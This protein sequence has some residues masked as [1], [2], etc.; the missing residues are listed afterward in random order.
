MS[1]KYNQLTPGIPDHAFIRGNVPMTKEEVRSITIAKLQLCKDDVFMDIGA[2]TGSVSVE[3][4]RLL[5]QSK[6]YAIEH[7]AEAVELIKQNVAK[8]E[9][10]NIEVIHA[11]ALEAFENVNGVNK[12]FIGGSSGQLEGIINWVTRNCG[13]GTRIVANA[14]TLDTLFECKKLFS[15]SSFSHPE[16]IQ[17]GITKVET[18][19]GLQMMRA[20]SPIFII[21]TEIV[22]NNDN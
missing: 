11:K 22:Q 18:V 2:G 7:K 10:A 9:L 1:K 20:H 12:I 5:P 13:V 17:V 14:V 3:V 21:T 4:A 6:V 8:F 19:A 15:S 16:I